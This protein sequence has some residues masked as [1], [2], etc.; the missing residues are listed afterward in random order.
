LSTASKACR[1]ACRSS[2]G[3]PLSLPYIRFLED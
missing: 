1:P 3:T 2:S